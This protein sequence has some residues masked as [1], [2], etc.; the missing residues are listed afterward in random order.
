LIKI[1]TYC[2][3]THFLRREF[4]VVD[5]SQAKQVFE[6]SQESQFVIHDKHFEETASK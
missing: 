4:H 6:S 2:D 3:L 5:F 1:S